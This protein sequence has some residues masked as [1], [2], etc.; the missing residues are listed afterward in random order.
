MLT[1]VKLGR[2]YNFIFH[3]PKKNIKQA[4]GQMNTYTCTRQQENLYL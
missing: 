2:E 3:M 4:F 1:F